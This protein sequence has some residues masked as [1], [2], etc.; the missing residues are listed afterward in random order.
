M[1]LQQ[2]TKISQAKERTKITRE[3]RLNHPTIRKKDD[4][5]KN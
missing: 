1:N 2:L 5:R 4:A 3:I